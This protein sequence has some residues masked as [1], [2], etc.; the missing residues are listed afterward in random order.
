MT[1]L[2]G[3]VHL[4]LL[5]LA[6][7]ALWA[8]GCENRRAGRLE[9]ERAHLLDE[10]KALHSIVEELSVEAMRV[11]T[12]FHVDTVDFGAKR[13]RYDSLRQRVAAGD[14]S[15]IT[16]LILLGDSTI[17][18]CSAA[19]ETCTTRV[20]LRDSIISQQRRAMAVKDSLIR[21]EQKRQPGFIK[22]RFGCTAGVAATTQ[23]AG[24]GASCGVRFP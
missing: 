5:V 12:V 7:L 22:R 2:K 11:D 21:V 3:H 18:A 6:L 15:K 23:G 24:L 17:K 10:N 9:Q 8:Y 13:G 20:A 4:V 1:W 19:L 16:P 14:T